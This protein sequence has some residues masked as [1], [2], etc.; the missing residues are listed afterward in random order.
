[1]IESN[2]TGTGLLFFS[3]AVELGLEPV[4][5]SDDPG[6]YPFLADHAS[7][8]VNELSA[9]AIVA[10]TEHLG[11]GGG[12][13]AGVWSSSDQGAELAAQVAQRLGLPHADP[14]AIALCRDKFAARRRLSAAGLSE[15][16]YALV[17]SG[18]EAATFASSLTGPSVVKP[19]SSTG[20]IG[21]RL[22]STSA[23]ARYH[24]EALLNGQASADSKGV[25]IEA[26]VG[27]QEYSV[28]LFDG[29]S[30]G[31]TRKM[32]GPPPTFVEIG[33]DFP[34]PGALADLA[35][36]A[37]HAELAIAAVGYSQGP[38][39]VEI[40][41]S[42]DGPVVIEINPRL[43]GG[44]IPELVRR[45]KRIDLI[46][47]SIRFACGL[48]YELFSSQISAASIRFLLRPT[49][50]P[51][52]TVEGL[53]DAR[54]L[55]GI[56]DAVVL[57][58]GFGRAG[59]IADFRDRIAYVIAEALVPEEAGHLADRALSLLHGVP[60]TSIGGD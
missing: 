11:E 20:S 16:K 35:A 26:V 9:A 40:R 32:L 39:H 49:S 60:A 13:I 30:V 4:L 7:V 41:L 45:A 42:T 8:R 10:A 47:T 1:M 34:S 18:E 43:A 22:C 17:T 33:H 56:V 38:A 2:T 25:L 31:V 52:H 36:I 48:P 12:T 5:I 57:D 23:E 58:R 15:I 14:P 46:K 53:P 37:K 24:A 51:V 59:P 55:K 54:C 3:R 29:V 50:T 21:V 28:E 44:M 19:R 6:R 27:G